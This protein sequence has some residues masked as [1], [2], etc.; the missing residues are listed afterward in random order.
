MI[1]ARGGDERRQAHQSALRTS[2]KLDA[3]NG[4]AL[5]TWQRL[6]QILPTAGLSVES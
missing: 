3:R 5:P 1:L 2:G 4:G 6:L